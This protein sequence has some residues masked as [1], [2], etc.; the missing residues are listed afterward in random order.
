MNSKVMILLWERWK[1]TR[2]AVIAA[3]LLPLIGQ[4]MH[5]TGY[6]TFDHIVGV[7]KTLWCLGFLLL[8]FIL[9]A[10]HCEARD[11]DLSF[12]E[13]LFRF[14]V[15]TTTLFAA[16]MGYGVAAVALQ[17]LVVF[18]FEKLFLDTI[19]YRWTHLL[20]FETVYIVLQTLSWLSWL[21]ESRI[22]F[23]CLSSLLTGVY[24]CSVLV[25]VDRDNWFTGNIILC[26]IIIVLLSVITFWSVSAH[27]HSDRI[28]DWRW[29]DSLLGIFRR[30]PSN[31]FASAL[32]AQIWFE[33]RQA[34]YLFPI[35]VMCVIG[36]L[37]GWWIFVLGP[38]ARPSDFVPVALG[39]SFFVAFI[40]GFLIFGL[41]HRDH[42]SGASSFWL[43]SPVSTRTLA[44]ARQHA[45][46]RSLVCVLAILTVV[47]LAVAAYD[48]A[49]ETRYIATRLSSVKWAFKYSSPLETVTM[50]ILG[51]YGFAVLYWTLLCLAPILLVGWVAVI[52]ISW[53][54]K[55]LIGDVAFFWI[56]YSLVVGLPLG[57]LGAFLV[58]R[59]RNLITTATLV[60]VFC[61][62]PLV[63]VSLWA[64]PWW[65][66]TGN[67]YL[68][69]LH[70]LSRSQIIL[71][72][73]VAT[74]PFIP[75]VA[76]PLWM[77]RL[78]HR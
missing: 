48:W 62:F 55:A 28:A 16:Y 60:I 9:L 40:A 68:K 67:M 26:P 42:V 33:M 34:G 57:V 50:T 45:M 21:L 49:T 39:I 76:T 41:H 72:A 29:I 63:V 54:I 69:G 3:C 61:V 19:S 58:A 46:V 64:F 27:R 37:L 17:F 24:M 31:Y 38:P 5:V 30:K 20:W 13:R 73:I 35:A 18:G 43:R 32:D 1:R 2:W 78:R 12:P 23:L 71:L 25:F 70:S 66:L 15:S 59:L 74:L 77:E 52:L 36:L 44:V 4:L 51:L 6:I 8:T 53:L 7:T 65:S 22:R 14:P 75:V 10:S 11:L 56:G 47:T